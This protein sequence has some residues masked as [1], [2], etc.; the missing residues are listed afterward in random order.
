MALGLSIRAENKIKVRQPLSRGLV[1]SS[2]KNIDLLTKIGDSLILDELNIGEI[3][4]MSSKNNRLKSLATKDQN[5]LTVGLDLTIT[6]DLKRK[7]LVREII[8]QV[9]DLRKQAELTVKD[10]IV[11]Y[12]ESKDSEIKKT[13]VS[14][15]K[16]IAHETR[17]S[18]VLNKKADVFGKDVKVNGKEIWLGIKKIK[19]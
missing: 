18:E 7:G 19:K 14:L 4:F 13:L 1:V 2:S 3:G 11:L 12:W 17:S 15:G 16:N 9:Q 8:R 5:N 6:P 10:Q